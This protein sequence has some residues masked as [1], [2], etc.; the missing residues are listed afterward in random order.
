MSEM[1]LVKIA[2]CV[3]GLCLSA[4]ASAN[5]GVFATSGKTMGDHTFIEQGGQKAENLKKILQN[6]KMPDGFKIDLYAIVP[7]ARDMA[8]APQGTVLFVGTRKDK[9][10]VVSDRDRDG[11]AD[12]VKDFA[13]SLSFDVPN[14]VR[15]NNDGFLF[16]AERNHVRVRMS[17]QWTSCRK[18]S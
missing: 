1:K 14:G 3:A 10:W 15:F 16:I 12:E 17:L 8:M 13:P 18:A 2:A 7:D 6:I 5:L 4:G 9:V 11:V